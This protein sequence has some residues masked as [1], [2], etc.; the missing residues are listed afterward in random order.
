MG[1]V[2]VGAAQDKAWPA[3]V[4]A[5]RYPSEGQQVGAGGCGLESCALGLRWVNFPMRSREKTRTLGTARPERAWFW[6]LG[7]KQGGV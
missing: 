6:V 5:G 2:P 7:G 4:G 3:C 1:R